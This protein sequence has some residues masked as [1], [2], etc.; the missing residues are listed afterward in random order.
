MSCHSQGSWSVWTREKSEREVQEGKSEKRREERSGEPVNIFSN[1]S[2][3]PLAEKP[4][5][6]KMSNV[7]TSKGAPV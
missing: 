7:K 6:V 4:F 1:A 3:R 2:I 5:L